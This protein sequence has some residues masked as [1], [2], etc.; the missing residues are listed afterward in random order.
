MKRI[1][2]LILLCIIFSIGVAPVIASSQTNTRGISVVSSDQTTG[3]QKEITLYNKSYAVIIGIDQYKN[4]PFDKQLS[5]AVKDAK[6]IETTLK[7]HFKFDKIITLYNKEATKDNIMKVLSGDL[8]KIS[9]EDSVFIFW[10]GHGYTEK[11]SYGDLGYLLPFDGTFEQSQLYKNISMTTLKDD[12]SKRIP[13]KHVFY[14]MDACYSGLLV[15]TRGSEER[16]T[17]RNLGYLQ[18]ITREKVRQVLTAGSK[19]QQVLDGGPMGHSVFTGRFIEALENTDDFI[20]ATELSSLVKEKVYSDAGSRSHV[21]TPKYGELFGLGDYVFVPSLERKVEDTQTR[22]AAL[23]AEKNRLEDLEKAAVAA[24]DE[25]ARRMAELEKK[26]LDAQLRAEQLKNERLAAEQKRREEEAAALRAYEENLARK[27]KE[28]EVRLTAL[29]KEVEVKRQAIGTTT[30]QSLSPEAT[31][32]EMK[33]IDAKIKEIK[34]NYR[35]ELASSI[36]SISQQLNPKFEKIVNSGQDEFESKEEFAARVDRM[37]KEA[38]EEQTRLFVQASDKVE[39]AY[40]NEVKPFIEEL[41]KLSGKEFTLMAQD[42]I[43]ELGQYN[44]KFDTYPVTIKSK[45]PMDGVFVACSADLPIP[46]EEARVFKQHFVNNILRPEISGNFQSIEFFRVAKAHVIDDAT[47]KKYNLFISEFVDLGNGVVLDTQ[48]KLLWSKNAQ[49]AKFK[50]SRENCKATFHE[51]LKKTMSE[52]AISGLKGWRI[53]NHK[54]IHKMSSLKNKTHPFINVENVR[55]STSGCSDH[56]FL[57]KKDSY[58][59]GGTIDGYIVYEVNTGKGN[60]LCGFSSP[61]IT[62]WPVL[63]T[64]I[65][66]P[67]YVIDDATNKKYDMSASQFVDLGNGIVFDTQT[68]LLWSKNAQ[69][70]KFKNSRENYM[71]TFHEDLER[72]MSETAI[73]GLKGWRIPNHKEID[74]MSSLKNK[75][76]PFINV[77]NVRISTSGCS[78]RG[79]L[80]KK[81]SFD[82]GG[83]ID[84]YTVYEV[85]TGKGNRLCGFSSPHLTIWP[86]RG[87]LSH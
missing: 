16:K 6:G 34:E 45:A 51:D 75:I 54:E 32:K 74:S 69:V 42:L 23:Q 15:A 78:D 61:N 35:R 24:K 47:N 44:A 84:G 64:Y 27:K 14:V 73:S 66:G 18:E 17:L 68:K 50:N 4:L 60:R 48:T 9:E 43:L 1:G 10:A 30:L 12:I 28:S 19:D 37:K 20:T 13:A 41:K 72:T 11:T 8:S 7:K 46:R 62:I 25:Q 2:M 38:G 57:V 59:S 76:H 82:S 49:I 77:E 67:A 85:N 87:E 33:G 21:Q 81:D 65:S 5:Y 70:A 36:S 53:P 26:A 29:Q 58:N 39:S 40:N 83:T 55:I 52:T 31:I 3:E 80:V 79:F 86:V 71:A 63:E 56:G 22:L